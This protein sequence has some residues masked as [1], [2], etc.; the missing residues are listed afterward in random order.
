MAPAAALLVASCGSKDAS[1]SEALGKTAEAVKTATDAALGAAAPAAETFGAKCTSDATCG[2]H[3][4]CD[5]ADHSAHANRR[6]SAAAVC[7]STTRATR[8]TAAPVRR[9]VTRASSGTRAFTIALHPATTDAMLAYRVFGAD[10]IRLAIVTPGSTSLT[11]HTFDIDTNSPHDGNTKCPEP[12]GATDAGCPTTGDVCK[13]NGVAP[14]PADPDC[15]YGVDRCTR[16]GGDKVHIIGRHDATS[17][18][19]LALIAYDK[20]INEDD[21]GTFRFESHLAVWDVTTPTAPFQVQNWRITGVNYWQCLG[22]VGRRRHVHLL[23][24]P[25][26]AKLAPLQRAATQLRCRSSAHL[27]RRSARAWA[28][29]RSRR[30]RAATVR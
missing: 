30:A 24:S 6:T 14:A 28:A 17:G 4:V 15:A 10:T 16:L 19:D 2:A 13:C 8:R 18:K 23:D 5:V 20:S 21:A 11:V 3:H 27:L 25:G 9:H 26:L 29:M 12:G 1:K 7:A 22:S